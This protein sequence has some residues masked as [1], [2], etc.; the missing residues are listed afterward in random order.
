MRRTFHRL[1]VLVLACALF[2]VTASEFQVAAMLTDISTDLQAP[3]ADLGLL[4][5]LYSLGMGFGG[6]AVAWALRRMRPK[7]ALVM[8]M[9][10]Y[11]AAEAIAGAVTQP[12]LLGVLRCVTGALSGATFGLALSAGMALSRAHN[13]TQVSALI[14]T[15]LM[16]GTLLGLP[17]SH[18][19]ATGA[20]W[21]S[22]FYLLA[23]AAAAMA[24]AVTLTLPSSPGGSEDAPRAVGSLRSPSLWARYLSSFLTIGG[25]FTAFAFIDPLL[26]A[27]KLAAAHVTLTMLGFGAAAFAVNYLTGRVAQGKARPWLGLG[28]TVQLAALLIFLAAPQSPLLVVPATMLLGGTGIALNPLLVNRVITV[29]KPD[30][31]VNTLHTSAITLGVA[32]ATAIGSRAIHASDGDL[33]GTLIAGVAFTIAAGVLVATSRDSHRSRASLGGAVEEPTR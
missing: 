17:L 18:L 8:V 28:L 4:V 3:V 33:A 29:A 5:T 13:R 15:G 22:S 26:Q 32:A 16:A 20:G 2:V 10:C 25:A 12:V 21:R 23:A 27:A 19:L 9:L 14:L 30:V 31:M 6:P 7:P 1:P 11:A 24:V